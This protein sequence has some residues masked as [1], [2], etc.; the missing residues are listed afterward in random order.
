MSSGFVNKLGL[1]PSM[2]L[3]ATMNSLWVLQSLIP[4][5][6]Y[7]YRD[8]PSPEWYYSE[9]FYYV[10]NIFISAISGFFG[11]LLWVGEGTYISECA[12]EETKGFYFSY[13][14]MFYMQ[15]QVFGN[16]IAAL[17]LGKMDQVSYFTVMSLIAFTASLS[18]A[19]LRKP[20]KPSI[21]K[22][23]KLELSQTD[24]DI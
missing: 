8:N 10:I 9:T 12:T 21:S 16:L 11:S 24:S 22:D 2:V 14:W 4:A 20:S 18:F 3:G 23:F 13:F 19:F 7:K 15:S 17:L 6:K 5:L 1:K